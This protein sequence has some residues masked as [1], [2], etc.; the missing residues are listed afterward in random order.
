MLGS[1][2][3]GPPAV[4]LV[5]GEAGIGKTRLVREFLDSPSGRAYKVLVATCPPL[6]QPHTLGAVADALRAAAPDGV[7]GLGLTAV[8][9]AL[10]PLFPEWS[11]DLP[12]P[13][14]PVEDASVARH[15]VFTALAGLL[16][17]L[18]VGLLVTEDVHWA[19]EATV[20]FL[21][22][23][24]SQ[25]PRPFDLVVTC[26][27][28][29]ASAGSLLRQLGRLTAGASGRRITLGPLDVAAT[30]GL[31]S[32]MLGHTPVSGEFAG[33]VHERTGGVPLAVEELV[34][35]LADRGDVVPRDGC[36]ARRPVPAIEVPPAVRDAVLE[37]AARLASDAQAVLRAA[38]V[39]ATPAAEEIVQAVTALPAERLRP[40]L[41]QALDSGL[42]AEDE[43]GLV[44][45]RHVLTAQAIDE[46]IPGPECRVMHLRAGQVLQDGQPQPLAR[47]TRHF[48][49]AGD[50]IRWSRYAEQA[51]DAE[52]AAGD[53]AGAG[54]LLCD[55]IVSAGLPPEE[56][57]RIAGK[58]VPLALGDGQLRALA[59]AFRCGLETW[60]PPAAVE[61]EIRFHLGRVLGLLG[62][63]DAARS[64]LE[65]ALPGLP[66]GS[67][68][69]LRA[70]IHL[71]WPGGTCYPAAVYLRWLRRAARAAAPP[72]TAEQL[73][74]L[75]NRA[76]ALLVL[77][78]QAGWQV[79]AEF[80][81][82]PSAPRERLVV[83]WAHWNIGEMAMVW[84][85]YREARR[86]LEQAMEFA[87]VFEQ[88][89]T[90]S[91]S[92]AALT[93][94]D[95]FTGRW[96][97]LATRA[98]ALASQENLELEARLRA[99]LVRGLLHRAQGSRIQGQELLAWVLREV[100]N[101]D[102]VD[103][104]YVAEPA[105][106][107][108]RCKLDAGDPGE[109]LEVIGEAMSI[110]A[111]KRT[112]VWAADLV[113]ARVEA[114]IAAGQLG[115]AAELVRVFGRGL[116][117]R[118]APAPKAGLALCRA[119][120]VEAHGEH[121]RAATLFRGAATAWDVLPRPYDA[122]LARERQARCL[123]A[124]GSAAAGAQ[125]LADTWQGLLDL[126]AVHD[127]DRAA[128]A[129]RERGMAVPRAWRG[130]RRGY[131]SRLSPRETEVVK[132]VA[133]GHTNTEIA[134]ALSRSPNTV[135]MQR[136]SAMRKLGVSSA[137]ALA[138]KAIELGL[139]PSGRP[140]G[141]LAADGPS[142]R[143]GR[144][145]QPDW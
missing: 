107:L 114:L 1:A 75:G 101:A 82:E 131:G 89:T 69:A 122:L 143:A 27:P 50:T 129:L 7:A 46:A 13:P 51:A 60:K 138:V 90:G 18:D 144:Y 124:A 110:V 76:I 5:E 136:K 71:G 74:L 123:L 16:A 128:R 15:M 72:D 26:R 132:L 4:V 119:I 8:A 6:H 73:R 113:P 52:L 36:W 106:A 87:K 32:S 94:L 17:R 31:M 142:P 11:A 97:G 81:G 100:R 86:R 79:A 21:L 38:A 24:A 80:P 23:V 42:L 28:E 12:A 103:C 77:G 57:S 62:E 102:A 93:H 20:E 70:M 95:W 84:G 54:S 59:R 41:S 117:G 22:C 134:T 14:E 127:A 105:A 145:T 91:N 137:A 58:I 126:G 141:A 49:R 125:L 53:D 98:D 34:R 67:P 64:E 118:D 109:A 88:R 61:A 121:D 83:T 65:Q 39:L 10:R 140:G 19:D 92:I 139:T 47:L 104:L 108:A 55:L 111:L 116:R 29:D 130:G 115:E 66:T 35:L 3:D 43:R 9:G 37:R 48:R 85:R 68:Q 133:A 63:Q 112:W 45:F 120:L 40:A 2:L 33:F 78:Q 56:M 99:S 30:V 44:A 135:A 96:D 25:Q